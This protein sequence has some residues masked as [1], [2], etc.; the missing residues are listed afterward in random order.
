M[1]TSMNRH[2]QLEQ[3]IHYHLSTGGKQLRAQLVLS[4]AEQVGL[5][6][7]KAKTWASVCELLHNA[8]LIHDDI[9]DND[10][11]RRGQAS[12]WKKYGLAQAINAGDLLIFRAFTLA[13]TL[14]NT[15]LITILAEISEKLVLGQSMELSPLS[16]EMNETWKYYLRMAEHKTGALFLLPSIGVHILSENSPDANKEKAWLSLGLC[17]Q[18]LDDLKDYYG[19][20]QQGQKQKD[21]HEKRLNALTSLLFDQ[22]CEPDLRNLYFNGPLETECSCIES[23][24]SKIESQKIP[25]RLIL[26]IRQEMS[27]MQS[28]QELETAQLLFDHVENQLLSMESK[29]E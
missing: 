2:Q 9:Q 13:S 29:N 19:L 16:S 24:V 17:Y 15:H 6:S 28:V 27:K 8:T 26:W 18:V 12:V 23:V 3:I 1:T 10:P 4:Q 14:N 22:G 7:Q 20:K 21:L 25:S 11:I 5:D